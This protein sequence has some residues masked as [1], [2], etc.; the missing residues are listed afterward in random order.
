M[1]SRPIFEPRNP[2]RQEILDTVGDQG[3]GHYR[4]PVHLREV[5]GKWPKADNDPEGKERQFINEMPHPSERPF[6]RNGSLK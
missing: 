2:T 3:E 6:V 1:A 4:N 5:T